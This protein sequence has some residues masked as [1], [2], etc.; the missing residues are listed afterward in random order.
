MSD[1]PKSPPRGSKSPSRNCT[2]VNKDKIMS[3]AT[4]HKNFSFDSATV[5]ELPQFNDISRYGVEQ[6]D[7]QRLLEKEVDRLK[8][9]A[10]TTECEL[11]DSKELLGRIEAS[12]FK[13]LN[14]VTSQI[15][16][17]IS[18]TLLDNGVMILE[19]CP[20]SGLLELGL[21]LIKDNY[22]K[23]KH[24]SSA[25]AKKSLPTPSAPESKRI[26]ELYFAVVDYVT[27]CLS[28]LLIRT[29]TNEFWI[30]KT[31]AALALLTVKLKFLSRDFT[32]YAMKA[33]S[34][35]ED[36]VKRHQEDEDIP[37][38]MRV[39]LRSGE[40][41]RSTEK[42]VM[43]GEEHSID[44]LYYATN[45][46][47]HDILSKIVWNMVGSMV[48]KPSFGRGYD[49]IQ[50]CTF[51]YETGLSQSLAVV[52]DDNSGGVTTTSS[53]INV[54]T[55][56]QA[57]ELVQ[58]VFRE[59]KRVKAPPQ[60][61]SPLSNQA[62]FTL[63]FARTSDG[64][65][66][67]ELFAGETNCTSKMDDWVSLVVPMS[68][69]DPCTADAVEDLVQIVYNVSGEDELI[70]RVQCPRIKAKCTMQTQ[71]FQERQMRLLEEDQYTIPIIGSKLEQRLRGEHAA[72]GITLQY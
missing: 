72:N 53:L 26:R 33:V 58:I 7:S 8:H 44:E 66:Q 47:I 20:K 46:G 32:L 38:E 55:C 29:I 30:P 50:Y 4:Q 1:P 56:S 49:D 52:T 36:A 35:A 45:L 11:F 41:G 43:V 42:E 27:S 67:Q 31:F 24:R 48:S 60:S 63:A 9:A 28:R 39:T 68:L 71:T 51:I 34:D 57:L 16:S 6:D 61:T 69:S 3:E 5:T 2:N 18:T 15:F 64:N 59:L 25:M 54:R 12:S 22:S 19:N 13:D 62:V 10:T 65:N 21:D 40:G 37:W 23:Q 17:N 70:K 14:N